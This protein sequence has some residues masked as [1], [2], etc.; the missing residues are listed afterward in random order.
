MKN[1]VDILSKDEVDFFKDN[2]Y[3]LVKNVFAKEKILQLKETCKW[4]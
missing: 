1:T 3:L 4:L 2:G